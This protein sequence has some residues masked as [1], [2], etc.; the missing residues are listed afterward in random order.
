MQRTLRSSVVLDPALPS[1]VRFVSGQ[2][3]SVRVARPTWS[4]LLV[5]ESDHTLVNAYNLALLSELAYGAA[6]K[7]DV[8][9]TDAREAH[10]ERVVTSAFDRMA[11]A[12]SRADATVSGLEGDLILRRTDPGRGLNLESLVLFNRPETETQGYAI[13]AGDYV[14][15]AFRGTETLRD[16]LRDFTMTGVDCPWAGGQV[17]GGFLGGFLSVRDELDEFL[18]LQWEPGT[19]VFLCGHSL[20]G[21]LA[22][23]AAAYVR[24]TRRADVVL[25]TYGA[26]RAGDRSFVATYASDPK[27]IAH[28]H[29]YHLDIVPRVPI[30]GQELSALSLMGPILLVDV[31]LDPWHHVGQVRVHRHP[32]VGAAVSYPLARSAGPVRYVVRRGDPGLQLAEAVDRAFDQIA[33][34]ARGAL[35]DL[36]ATIPA[37]HLITDH[38][39]G[40]YV[41]VNAHVMR[42]E[43][44]EYLGRPAPSEAAEALHARFRQ[45]EAEAE[46]D[47]FET[48]TR[49]RSLRADAAR[50]RFDIEMRDAQVVPRDVLVPPPVVGLPP[51]PGR[52]QAQLDALRRADEI[53]HH[54]DQV[55]VALD[56][57]L[58]Y[59]AWLR[60]Q[61]DAVYG[62]QGTLAGYEPIEGLHDE[63]ARYRSVTS[64]ASGSW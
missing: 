24:T 62:H 35:Y 61:G 58:A 44:L 51:G 48:R 55:Q 20:G 8:D 16:W 3:H 50:L 6:G 54:A 9:G 45:L 7:E 32:A 4:P 13:A 21:A 15:V 1:G 43:I 60:S 41:E 34:G 64:G 49:L 11:A 39:I 2:R 25:Y 31:D 18:D 38:F 37:A 28:R 59:L 27:F 17:H 23:V 63:L 33:E 46:A 12:R 14:L 36:D 53:D 52:S 22:T 56:A 47:V 5:H 30:P 40:G 42:Q 57:D 10:A 26:P 19:P 29:V